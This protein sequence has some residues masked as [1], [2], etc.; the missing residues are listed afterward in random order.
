MTSRDRKSAGRALARGWL[1]ARR[2]EGGGEGGKGVYL[3]YEDG[4]VVVGLE[5]EA[6]VAVL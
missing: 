4:E 3:C 5:V 6:V 1:L 2:E